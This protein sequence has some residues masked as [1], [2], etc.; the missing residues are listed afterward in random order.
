MTS[1]PSLI[2][3]ARR[4]AERYGSQAVAY[5][6]L[7]SPHLRC[8]ARPVLQAVPPRAVTRILDIG[9][10][11]GGLRGD[12]Q[13]AFPGAAVL[14]VDHSRGMLALAP[15]G[16][17]VALMDASR[18]AV[19]SQTFDLAILA[20]VLFHLPDP[21]AS[22]VEARRVLRPGGSVMT[23]TWGME[24]A[25]DATRIWAEEL[26]RHGARPVGLNAEPAHHRLMDTPEKIENLLASAGFHP[27]R[28]WVEKHELVLDAAD[29]VRLRTACGASK[30]R[31]ESLTPDLRLVCLA[32]AQQRLSAMRPGAFVARADVVYSVA[33]SA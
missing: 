17:H 21:H 5:R 4:V 13:R 33:R 12:M 31:F 27:V 9:T 8:F 18:L 28:C 29:L 10:G 11:V 32:S 2:E 23:I 3:Q 19:A 24:L 22:L 6:D 16:Q 26:D 25:S 7:W 14:G 15:P 1:D 20:F 30:H